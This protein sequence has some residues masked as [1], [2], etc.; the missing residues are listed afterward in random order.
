MPE[1]VRRRTR[2]F[3][4]MFFSLDTSRL[5]VLAAGIQDGA[6]TTGFSHWRL[7]LAPNFP[8]GVTYDFFEAEADGSSAKAISGT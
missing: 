2:L 4:L 8:A 3:A 1:E 5:R 7:C 6:T